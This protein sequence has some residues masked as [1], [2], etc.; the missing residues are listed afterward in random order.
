MIPSAH[1]KGKRFSSDGEETLAVE[2]IAIAEIDAPATP[3]PPGAGRETQFMVGNSPAMRRVFELIRRFARTNVPVLITGESGT[4]KELAARA[5]RD[6]SA[7]SAGPFVPVNCAC[8]PPE[9]IAS[10]LFG[11]EKGAFTGAVARTRG[12]VEA[13]NH[14]TLFLDEIGDLGVSL[15]AHLL[16]FL[17]EG[18]IVRVGGRATIP[19]DVRIISATNIDLANAVTGGRFREDLYYR[20]N[21]LN[22]QMPPLRER[23]DDIHVLAMFFL[24]RLAAEF[25][26]KISD[27]DAEAQTA[28]WKHRWPGNVR[29]LIAAIRRAVVVGNTPLVS[30]SD[31]AI[32]SLRS[33]VHKHNLPA[34]GSADE[35]EA[36]LAALDRHR[37]VVSRVAQEFGV[38]R[39]TLY[40][41]L[42][43]HN[44]RPPPRQASGTPASPAG[45]RQQAE[46]NHAC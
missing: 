40:R 22:L 18:R 37:Q 12:L 43:R 28:L 41:L 9:L 1:G 3:D 25:G 27:F 16:R 34:P 19:V 36:L 21:V 39:T 20:L 31:L 45:A 5:I 33:P 8:L 24:R 26:R 11:Y 46:R 2:G 6:Y 35:R 7:R 23:G 17:Q 10:E 29:E 38:S 14:G 30:V 4:G 32:D 13:A 44:L 42:Y 15:Q